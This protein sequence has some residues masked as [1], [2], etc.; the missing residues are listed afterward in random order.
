MPEGITVRILGDFGPFSRMG[1][2]IGYQ[3]EVGRHTFLIDCGAPLFQQIGGHG[4]KKIDGLIITHCHDDHKRWFSDLA[5]FN[6][7]APDVSN[8]V[9]LIASEDVHRDIIAASMPA[10]EKS[11]SPDSKKVIDISYEQYVDYRI[12]GP[13]ARYR[14]VS[15]DEGGGKKALCIQDLQGRKVGPETAKIIISTRT[16]APRMLFHDP[17]YREWVEPETFYPFSSE[18]F[19]DQDQNIYRDSAGFSI[20]AIKAPVWHG[21]AGIGLRVKAGG[22][23]LT[24][25][26]DTSHDLSL[27]QQLCQEKR[28]QRRAMS[29]KEFEAALIITG[30]INDYTERT[31]SEERYKEAITAFDNTPVIHDV[32]ARGSVVHTDYENLGRTTLKKNRTILT[33]SPDKL[34]SEWVLC[35]ANKSFRVK[36]GTFFEL[37]GD[38]LFP[39][40]ADLYHK[41]GGRYFVGYKHAQGRYAVFLRDGLLEFALL[42]EVEDEQVL[43]RVDLYEDVSGRYFPRL[44]DPNLSYVE[45]ADGRV[46]LVELTEDGSKGSIVRSKRPALSQTRVLLNK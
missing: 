12:I 21:V 23:T 43:Y 16:G 24:F 4:L 26:S 8:K 27:W 6:L 42:G 9:F 22:E 29:E 13:R 15:L 45:R 33:H 32:S 41:E 36:D 2:S 10:L 38:E 44:D 19:Y 20:E 39:L 34:T 18:T 28:Q 25:S 1:K 46:E 35:R 14:I 40:N 30:D 5:L 7:Y 3:L 31:W 37:V 11:L 17:V